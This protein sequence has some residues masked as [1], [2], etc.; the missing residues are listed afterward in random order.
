MR[1]EIQNT[2]SSQYSLV[3]YV[4]LV[5]IIQYEGAKDNVFNEIVQLQNGIH[6]RESERT[7]KRLRDLY[8]GE[9]EEVKGQ[10]R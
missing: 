8:V 7:R 3:V 4:L 6:Q 9:E 5:I 1:G 10:E 2:N